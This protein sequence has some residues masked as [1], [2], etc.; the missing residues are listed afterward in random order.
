[1]AG[2]LWTFMS[3]NISIGVSNGVTLELGY[4]WG[5]TEFCSRIVTAVLDFDHWVSDTE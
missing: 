1:M 3:F 2:P 4:F 5:S